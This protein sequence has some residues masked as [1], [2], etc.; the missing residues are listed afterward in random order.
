MAS[1][2]PLSVTC[3]RRS[4]PLDYR[5]RLA[6]CPPPDVL[7]DERVIAAWVGRTDVP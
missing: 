3:S 1:I 5:P 2:H 7:N 4:T 6:E